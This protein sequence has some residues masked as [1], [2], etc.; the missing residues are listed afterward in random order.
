ML[1]RH[2]VFNFTGQLPL[3]RDVSSP[4][5]PCDLGSSTCAVFFLPFSSSWDR[6]WHLLASFCSFD[7]WSSNLLIL[8]CSIPIRQFVFVL[9]FF[10]TEPSPDFCPFSERIFHQRCVQKIKILPRNVFD[11]FPHPHWIFSLPTWSIK[12]KNFQLI[13]TV[14][15]KLNNSFIWSLFP[16]SHISWIKYLLVDLPP[17]HPPRPSHLPPYRLHHLI[18]LLHKLSH[19]PQFANVSHRQLARVLQL[20]RTFH[21]V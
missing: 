21:T 15:E 16:R 1:F 12:V 5:C 20:Q 2:D 9:Q 14:T 7:L 3:W 10:R 6:S 17:L 18:E 8:I 11:Q 13:A 19:V 4:T